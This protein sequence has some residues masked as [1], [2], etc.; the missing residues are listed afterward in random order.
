MAVLIYFPK[1]MALT[2]CRIAVTMSSSHRDGYTAFIL[3]SHYNSDNGCRVFRGWLAADVLLEEDPD[4]MVVSALI[5]QPPLTPD[6]YLIVRGLLLNAGLV[7]VD[8]AK[9]LHLSPFRPPPDEYHFQTW[10]PAVLAVCSVLMV[11]MLSA[12]V[13]RLLVRHFKKGLSP[14]LDDWL[15]IPAL[16]RFSWVTFRYGPSWQW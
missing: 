6:D 1:S 3:K 11:V 2:E 9:S 12:T 10:G 5:G 8:P 4:R 14:G 13:D 7:N 15:I 16:V